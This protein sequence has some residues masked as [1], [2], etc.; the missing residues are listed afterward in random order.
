M[1]CA[2]GIYA[3]PAIRKINPDGRIFK[4]IISRE[5]FN[6]TSGKDLK[7]IGVNYDKK[8]TVLVDNRAYNFCCQPCNGILV[9]D[10]YDDP[11]DKQLDVVLLL[12][13]RLQYISDVQTVLQPPLVN[14]QRCYSFAD[15][16]IEHNIAKSMSE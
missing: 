10:F 8:R 1:T 15:E 16:I 5:Q 9:R 6:F 4:R 12:L 14:N 7:I 2:Q 11:N 3:R 13:K